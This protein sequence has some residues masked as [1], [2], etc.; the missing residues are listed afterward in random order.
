MIYNLDY[1]IE[2]WAATL[3][4]IDFDGT[5]I[6][7]YDNSEI[8]NLTSLPALPDH[9]Q[10]DIPLTSQGWNWTL[11]EIKSYNLLYPNTFITV[12]PLYCTTDEKTYIVAEQGS[13]QTISISGTV[14][15]DWMDGTVETVSNDRT[16]HVLTGN[17]YTISSSSSYSISSGTSDSAMGK[18][19]H[20]RCGKNLIGLTLDAYGNSSSSSLRYLNY[21]T[22]I[23]ISN[24]IRFLSIRCGSSLTY[25]NKKMKALVLP[26]ASSQYA[27]NY[28]LMGFGYLTCLASSYARTSI[29]SHIGVLNIEN[30]RIGRFTVP[31]GIVKINSFGSRDLTHDTVIAGSVK[32]ILDSGYFGKTILGS[33]VSELYN[34]N[35]WPADTQT[36]ILKATY[37]P[38]GVVTG[39]ILGSLPAAIYVPYSSNHSILNSYRNSRYWSNYA[40]IIY[41]SP[42]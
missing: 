29:P 28:T 11:A 41:E 38:S 13:S 9:T 14:E 7:T 37:P 32:T 35:F 27:S 31:D 16:T 5:V 10:D 4:F 40:S 33:N 2:N 25:S 3:M 15:I 12:G 20:V 8:Q 36:L 42:Q 18:I 21:L 39:T 24:Y 34:L 6:R 26:R 23:S 19:Y 30:C 22:D 17:T 1:N